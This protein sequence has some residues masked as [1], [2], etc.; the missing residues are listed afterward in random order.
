M[1]ILTCSSLYK[2]YRKK[3]F[4]KAS[5]PAL[6]GLDL[7]ID[8]G[9]TV[10]I[11]GPNGAGKSTLIKSIMGFVSVDSGSIK[12]NDR[13]P[14]DPS[15]RINIGYLPEICCLYEN[16]SITEHFKFASQ[17]SGIPTTTTHLKTQEVLHLVKLEHV[18]S[19]PIR[20]F[21]KGMK[22][23]AALAL[24]LLTDPKILILDEPMS[25]LDPLGRQIV[26]D[27]VRKF[28]DMGTTI[29]FC[30]H[31][32]NDVERICDRIG[33]M[34]QGRIVHQTSPIELETQHCDRPPHLTPLEA[35][36]LTAVSPN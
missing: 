35:C 12:I 22:Q 25:G 23:R 8:S 36:F 21:S 20:K 13:T 5:P 34:D 17:V 15:S 31:V 18:A 16:L 10:G 6:H 27:I 19:Q 3:L 32:L 11:I 28:K 30:S 4:S 7:S 2:T 1:K 29:L 9:E 14:A 26:I 24:A 33:I